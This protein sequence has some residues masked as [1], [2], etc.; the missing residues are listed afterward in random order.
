MSLSIHSSQLLSA[1]ALGALLLGCQEEA[2]KEEPPAKPSASV[3]AVAPPPAPSVQ[4]PKLRDDCPDGSSGVGTMAQPCLGK[5]DSRMM[6]VAYTGKTTDEGP[7]FSIINKSKS[8]I[9]YGSLA[10]YFYDK[11]GKQ[12]DVTTG[13]KPQPMQLCSG[14]IFAGAVKPGEKI[15]MFFSCVKKADIPA[16]TDAIEAE[17]KT[18]GFTDE[19]A[20]DSDYYWSNP[21]LVPNQRPKSGGKAKAKK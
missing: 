11:A 2:K 8:P 13:S 16:G 20:R 21:D 15:F 17:V 7:K 3:A 1:V 19:A 4:P 9:L 6:E 5:G 12:L 10:V 14:R 18:V